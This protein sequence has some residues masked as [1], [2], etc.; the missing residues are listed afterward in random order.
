GLSQMKVTAYAHGRVN[1]IGEHT[2]YN[3]GFVLPT[4]IPQRTIVTLSKKDGRKVRVTSN[5]YG[6][7]F[8]YE[9]GSEKAR[10]H[11][12]DYVQGVT[13]VLAREGFLLSGF[14]LHIE[15]NIPIGSGLSSS[16]ALEVALMKGLRELFDLDLR[17]GKRIAR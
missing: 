8:V 12:A 16:A 17:D 9:L 3:D 15:S 11:W 6:D 10:K 13:F 1:L 7:E 14:D 4:A 2:D 5:Q